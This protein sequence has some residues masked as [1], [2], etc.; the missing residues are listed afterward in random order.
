VIAEEYILGREVYVGIIGNQRLTTLPVIELDFGKLAPGA[1]P[2]AT[3]KVKWDRKYQK[4]RNITWKIAKLPDELEHRLIRIAKRV[5]RSLSLSGYGRI[6]FRITE[7][8][9]IYFIEANPNCDL[10]FDDELHLAA[11]GAGLSYLKLLQRIL[12]LG[13]AYEAEWREVI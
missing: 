9:E 7:D 12:N 10:G 4:K 3:S 5:Y 8:G 11:K 2:I 1:Q 13:L 6:D